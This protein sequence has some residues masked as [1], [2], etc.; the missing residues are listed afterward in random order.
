MKSARAQGDVHVLCSDCVLHACP[1]HGHDPA[2]ARRFAT[3]ARGD[4][5]D[6]RQGDACL[7]FRVVVSGTAATCTTFADGRR[8]ILGIESPGE[9]ICGAMAGA[10]TQCW[11]EALDDCTVCDLDLSATAGHLRTDPEFL[12]ISFR[13]V[14]RRLERSQAHLSTLGRLDSRERVLLFLVEMDA[15]HAA[16]FPASPVVRLPMSREDIADY[17][18]LNSET[19]S[20]ILTQIRKSGLIKFLNRNEYV[21]PDKDAIARRLPVD[22]PVPE[23]FRVPGARVEVV[24]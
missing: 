2:A 10:G 4:R 6:T 20:R 5:I 22:L 12:A 21:L 8:Q 19:V 9:V 24:Q 17:L 18:G 13:I 3:L 16:E 1:M 23:S 14:H 7:R 15:R 11:L